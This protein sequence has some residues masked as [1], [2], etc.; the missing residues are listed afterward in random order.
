MKF[1]QVAVVAAT[2]LAVA[3]EASAHASATITFAGINLAQNGAGTNFDGTFF[4]SN[5][6]AGQSISQ[7]FSYAVKIV[8]DG[9]SANR[10][11]STCLPLSLVDCGPAPTGFE[12]VQVE[13]ETFRDGREAN[14]FIDFTG[15]P[16]Q[17][18]FEGAAGQT[19]IFSG[20]FSLTET[21]TDQF[22]QWADTELLFA[23]LWVD[24]NGLPPVPEPSPWVAMISGLALIG[25]R[26]RKSFS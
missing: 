24:S 14:P 25:R 15:G 13:L 12:Q 11:W 22:G 4:G 26:L 16:A 7:Q 20:T 19:S 9:L 6:A 1:K 21:N 3:S 8:D 5:L 18:V 23:A 17:T 10:I 2:L